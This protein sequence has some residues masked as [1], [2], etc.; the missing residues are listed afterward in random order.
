M[1]ASVENA[2]A[3]V[4]GWGV[5]VRPEA[6][7]GAITIFHEPF[8]SVRFVRCSFLPLA[9]SSSFHTHTSSSAI[10]YRVGPFTGTSMSS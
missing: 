7:V 4:S 6:Q 2:P 3:A 10:I 8:G 5:C 9:G 1:M